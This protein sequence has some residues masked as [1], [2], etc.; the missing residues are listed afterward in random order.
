[1]KLQPLTLL[2]KKLYDHVMMTLRPR[3]YIKKKIKNVLKTKI[4]L[5]SGWY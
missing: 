3:R 4:G 2:I 1:M 5:L